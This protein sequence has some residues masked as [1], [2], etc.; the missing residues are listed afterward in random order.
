MVNARADR[1]KGSSGGMGRDGFAAL[2]GSSGGGIYGWNVT[3]RVTLPNGET[4]D[5]DRYIEAA[6]APHLR[7]GM[8]LPIRFD[9]GKASRV[10]IDVPA[11]NAG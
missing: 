6:S 3:I 4:A 9:P 2:E 5:F 1:S 11:L 10:E 7:P 8:T